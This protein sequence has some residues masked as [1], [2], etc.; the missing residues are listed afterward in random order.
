MEIKDTRFEHK[1][2]QGMSVRKEDMYDFLDRNIDK[3]KKD[4]IKKLAKK[5]KLKKDEAEKIYNSWRKSYISN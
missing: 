1:R 3:T 5:F 2:G 4:T